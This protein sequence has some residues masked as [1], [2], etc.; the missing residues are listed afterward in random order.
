[1]KR[2]LIRYKTKPDMADKNAELVAA[3]FAELKA[4]QAGGR[5]LSD[6]A[7]GGRHVHPFRRDRRAMTAPARCR[8]WRRFRHSR[9]AS[10]SAA[11]SRRWSAARRSSATTAC[12]TS[13]EVAGSAGGRMSV[14]PEA[15][16]AV[17]IDSL[18]VAMR[19][20]LHRYCARMV[21][22][23]IDGEDVLQDAL[24]KAVE[25]F[26]SAGADPQSR[27]LAVS[28]RAQHGAGFPAPPRPAGGA[29]IGGGGG[30]DRRPSLTRWQAARSP[31]P[32]CAPSCG[33]R[34]RSAPA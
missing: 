1:M 33:C 17:D 25:A 4:A 24:I 5:A 34:W 31:R 9:T 23:V 29:P 22:S 6:A 32:A 3:V 13:P 7:A 19:P 14:I 2:T 27:G 8:N 15:A 18:L 11:P 28:D 26:A 21:G 30:H 10:A 20:K 16:P 12:W